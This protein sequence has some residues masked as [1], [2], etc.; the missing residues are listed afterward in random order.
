MM[1][2]VC[3]V[4]LII[5]PKKSSMYL[6]SNA[7]IETT[8][9][10]VIQANTLTDDMNNAIVTLLVK[11]KNNPMS[12]NSKISIYVPKGSFFLLSRVCVMTLSSILVTSFLVLQN[13]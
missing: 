3:V 11:I 4:L 9:I 13:I 7:R 12:I 8:N 1:Q 10:V 5:T 2:Y 6:L